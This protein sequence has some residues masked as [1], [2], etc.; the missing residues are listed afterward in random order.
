MWEKIPLR[1]KSSRDGGARSS[2]LEFLSC[3]LA[4]ACFLSRSWVKRNHFLKKMQRIVNQEP[5]ALNVLSCSPN[6]TTN[7]EFKYLNFLTNVLFLLFS[8]EQSDWS[9]HSGNFKIRSF[10]IGCWIRWA[11][12]NSLYLFASNLQ[13]MVEHD[14][15]H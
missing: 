11:I 9:R 6:R 12:F 15:H 7:S 10:K 2:S 5:K 14:P 8:Q 1:F 13:E 4:S 3:F